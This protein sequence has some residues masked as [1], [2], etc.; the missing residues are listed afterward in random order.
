MIADAFTDRSDWS[1]ISP[2]KQRDGTQRKKVLVVGPPGIGKTFFLHATFDNKLPVK[3]SET[4]G[5]QKV[6]KKSMTNPNNGKKIKLLI[7]EAGGKQ[8]FEEIDPKLLSDI[9]VVLVLVENNPKNEQAFNEGLRVAEEYLNKAEEHCSEFCQ[10][11]LIVCRSKK[12]P[13]SAASKKLIELAAKFDGKLEANVK[14]LSEKNGQV[15]I[16]QMFNA[17]TKE[18]K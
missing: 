18:A 3:Y 2:T 11:L 1:P 8:K 7:Y 6:F 5:V 13:K 16:E 15:L 4:V 12:D 9:G 14:T 17:V 10:K